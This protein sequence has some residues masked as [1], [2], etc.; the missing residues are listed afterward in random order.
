MA[1]K[2]DFDTLA[3]LD[4]AIV[5]VKKQSAWGSVTTLGLRAKLEKRTDVLD[6][7]GLDRRFKKFAEDRKK[8]AQT[9]ASL[10]TATSLRQIKRKRPV[11]PPRLGRDQDHIE[12]VLKWRVRDGKVVL[13]GT[14]LNSRSKHWLI[15]EIG[16]NRSVTIYQGPTKQL[17]RSIPTQRGRRISSGL[18]F[19]TGPGGKYAAPGGSRNQQLYLRSKVKGAPIVQRHVR[20]GDDIGSRRGNTIR[21]RKEIPGQHFVRDGG[22][23]GFLQYRKSVLAAA[24]SQFR[25]GPR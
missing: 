1:T 13:N 16:T 11:A 5:R 12:D 18:V 15:Q 8:A 4:A 17:V 20:R 24:R 25:R 19:A 14:D 23:A 21:I 6:S 7:S 10:A 9:A 3:S 2:I 22:K